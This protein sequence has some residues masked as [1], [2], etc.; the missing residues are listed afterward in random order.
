MADADRERRIAFSAADVSAR[1]AKLATTFAAPDR[2]KTTQ[3]GMA[4]RL[5]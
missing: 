4:R 2:C 3:T 5:L 1:R